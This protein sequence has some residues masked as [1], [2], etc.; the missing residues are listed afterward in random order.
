MTKANLEDFIAAYKP[1]RRSERV[2]GERFRHFPLYTF[3]AHTR[4]ISMSSDS[5]TVR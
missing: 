4:S 1:G 3:L 5:S 2:E